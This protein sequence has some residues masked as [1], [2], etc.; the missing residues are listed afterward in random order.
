MPEQVG[1]FLNPRVCAGRRV[2]AKPCGAVPGKAGLPYVPLDFCMPSREKTK[3]VRHVSTANHE[4]S[5]IE[6]VP[7][8][9][10]NPPDSLRL[11]LR[12]R[13]RQLPSGDVWINGSNGLHT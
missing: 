5:A 10:G 11:D 9:L 2:Y 13:W 3:K 1:R 12:R 8:E 7:D 4:A 6:G